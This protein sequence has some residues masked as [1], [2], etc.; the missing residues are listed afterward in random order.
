MNTIWTN[1]LSVV[2]IVALLP[3]V[4]TF[5]SIKMIKW[6]DQNRDQLRNQYF[7]Y[8]SDKSRR[9]L[10]EVLHQSS[11]YSS[12]GRIFVTVVRWHN[13]HLFVEFGLNKN[14]WYKSRK[15]DKKLFS[16]KIVLKAPNSIRRDVIHMTLISNIDYVLNQFESIFTIIKVFTVDKVFHFLWKSLQSC[17]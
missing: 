4:S 2:F 11:S 3:S 8:G 10:D 9:F 5:N 12:F 14:N 13:C 15:S 7:N 16:M 1:W 17:H 6:L